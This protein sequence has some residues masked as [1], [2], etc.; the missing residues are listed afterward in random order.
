MSVKTND[1][2]EKVRHLQRTLYH[3]AKR[4]P[5]RRF[6]ALYDKV[7][8]SDI[9][10][11]AWQGVRR[12]HGVGGIDGQTLEWIEQEY[13][14]ENFL[15][16]L[17]RELEE[18]K[19]HP[20][21]VK[22]VEIPKAKGGVR[23]L[24]IPTI[25]DRVV[26][27][28]CRMVMEPIFEAD[29]L[30]CSYG[31]RPKRSA[32]QAHFVIEEAIQHKGQNWVIDGD[33]EKYFDSVEHWKLMALL[34]LRI[35]D[36]KILKLIRGWLKAGIMKEGEIEPTLE[37]TPQGGVIS[38]L[39]S[40]V[41][42]HFFDREWQRKYAHLGRLVRYVDDFVILFKVSVH[43]EKG[44]EIVRGIL[45]RLGLKLHPEKTRLVNLYWGKAGI[46]FLGFHFRRHP[47]EPKKVKRHV[48]SWPSKH[49]M[50]RI[51]RKIHDLTA[52]PRCST[53][54]LEDVAE[55]LNPV[56]RG[57]ANYF[58]V[59]ANG[60]QK[61]GALDLYVM[62]RLGRLRRMKHRNKRRRWDSRDYQRLG[63]FHAESSVK[64]DSILK[65]HGREVVGKPYDRKGHVR[66]D[67]GALETGY[68]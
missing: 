47:S 9:L 57:W 51:R 17:Q 5:K 45:K 58:R 62:Q 13:G 38:P 14:V 4:N 2:R 59:A 23:P 61:F 27:A 8:R 56:I 50:K 66:F 3:A 30:D 48:V 21:P 46:D 41:Y 49:A 43:A 35:S 15:K 34:K 67:E 12:N 60:R 55:R 6:H 24:G 68:G 37:G 10:E 29:F 42:L 26:Q 11:R 16:E 22:R 25:R 7:Y 44:L 63:V 39:L 52:S 53:V 36:R 32:H 19:Y 28:A 65:A 64:W 40:N 33:I 54:P 20:R 31:F 1:S 18:G